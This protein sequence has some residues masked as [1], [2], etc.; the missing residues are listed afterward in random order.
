MKN[1]FLL[2]VLI[3]LTAVA[4]FGSNLLYYLGMNYYSD[5]NYAQAYK[6]FDMSMY[7]PFQNKMAKLYCV[8]SLLNLNA[9]YY[10][11]KKIFEFAYSNTEDDA[12]KLA[13]ERVYKWRSNI[14]SKIGKNY[15]EYAP[16][17]S[18][19]IR[20]NK[21]SFPLKYY[22]KNYQNVPSY[23]VSSIEQSLAG[24]RNTIDFMSF[25]K[26]N[27]ENDAQI[28]FDFQP[29]PADVCNGKVCKYVVAYTSP[30][31]INNHLKNMVITI[32][33]KNPKGEYYSD[34]ELFNTVLHELGHAMGI[35]GHSTAKTDI[36][37]QEAHNKGFFK[38]YSDDYHN[39]T[40][41]DI[42]TIKLLYML[43]PD[44]SDVYDTDKSKLIYTPIV[45]GSRTQRAL[46]KVSEAKLYI[47]KSPNITAGYVN[48]AAAYMELGNHKEALLALNKAEKLAK[49]DT[50]RYYVYYNFAYLYLSMNSYEKAIEYA[51][52]A[53]TV[54]LTQDLFEL[55]EIIKSKM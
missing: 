12:S 39:I 7:L 45:L 1:K 24:W 52:L 40:S 26:T 23:Y 54:N 36:M 13:K 6:L 9:D 5:K 37:Y 43:E 18:N 16:A 51:N 21:K 49:D 19:L 55:I 15:I 47:K 11:Q 2:T 22:I 28:I 33:D 32:Y 48:L 53:K 41:K 42:N 4:L 10:V 8:K 25:K 35:M 3:I 46:K 50:E 44:V 20:W 29:L 27:T 30:L 38:P 17:D 31:V 14:M 34:K